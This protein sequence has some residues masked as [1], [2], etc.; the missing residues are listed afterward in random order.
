MID[1]TAIRKA[2][3]ELR[4]ISDKLSIDAFSEINFAVTP[5]TVLQS[6]NALRECAERREGC[7]FCG[8]D[9]H[10]IREAF[11]DGTAQI[12]NAMH[13][14]ALRIET[15]SDATKESMFPINFCPMCGRKLERGDA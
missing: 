3:K 2:I 5:S 11:D 7:E 13:S 10:R 9:R 15:P 1:L 6:L 12:I 8:V 4:V 14:F